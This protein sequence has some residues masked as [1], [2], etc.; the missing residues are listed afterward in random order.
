[1]ILKIVTQYNCRYKQ[2][3]CFIK[4]FGWYFFN[5]RVRKMIAVADF[6]KRLSVKHFKFQ[7]SF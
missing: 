3:K 4:K 1:M 2:F 5:G 7:F 6:K